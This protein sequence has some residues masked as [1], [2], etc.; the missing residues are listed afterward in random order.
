MG[1]TTGTAG[2]AM[3]ADAVK[4]MSSGSDLTI[5]LYIS[6]EGGLETAISDEARDQV[7]SAIMEQMKRGG[8]REYKRLL[9]F[10]HDVLLNNHELNSGVL[11]VGEGPGTI[12]RKVG[13]HL[14]LMLGSKGCSVFVAPVVFRHF[15]GL[16][17]TDKACMS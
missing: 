1:G 16:F 9:C 12:G 13:E 6:P 11:R 2:M 17:G 4:A 14:R 15:V 8:I 7:F 10:D 3:L 5:V